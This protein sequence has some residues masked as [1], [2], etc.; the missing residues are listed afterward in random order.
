MMICA[1]VCGLLAAVCAVISVMHFRE[2]GFLFN[3]AYIWASKWER[4]TMD[5]KLHYRQSGIAFA[6]IAALF[7]VMALESALSTGWLWIAAGLLAA[8]VLVYA[9]A[10]AAKEQNKQ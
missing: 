5:K 3:N 7:A 10:S 9:I 1:V 4:E 8:A 2:R 6:M